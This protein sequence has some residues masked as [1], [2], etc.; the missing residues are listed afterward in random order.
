MFVGAALGLD[1]L[2][3]VLCR[4]RAVD[5][6]LEWGLATWAQDSIKEGRLKDIVDFGIRGQISPRCLKKFARIIK[7]CLDHHP[8]QRPTMSEVVL[9][10]EYVLTIQKKTNNLLE[11]A[12]KTIFRRMILFS[13]S[14]FAY[15]NE[16]IEKPKKSY[17]EKRTKGLI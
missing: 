8:K 9:E 5:D 6:S 16:N 7:R 12:G 4:K 14:I 10:L 15:I 17:A 13:L 2:H 3:T 1:Y 11:T